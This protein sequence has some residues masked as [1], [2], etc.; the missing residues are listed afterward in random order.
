MVTRSYHWGLLDDL[1]Y[2]IPGKDNYPGVITESSYGA[3]AYTI[4]STPD[5]MVKLNTARYHR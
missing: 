4:K 3:T 5:N 1:M 2:Q